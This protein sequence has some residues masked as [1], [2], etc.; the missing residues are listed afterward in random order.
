MTLEKSPI[1]IY[2]TNGCPDCVRVRMYLDGHNIAYNWL[3]I[4]EDPSACEYVEKVNHGY[5]SVPTIVWPDGSL[6]VEPSI[7]QLIQKLKSFP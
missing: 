1:Q 5:Q 4:N 2:G 6:L 3:N 7:K